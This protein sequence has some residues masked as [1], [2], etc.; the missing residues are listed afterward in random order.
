MISPPQKKQ[1]LED[2]SYNGNLQPNPFF[3]NSGN[4]AEFSMESE[5]QNGIKSEQNGTNGE[6]TAGCNGKASDGTEN[7]CSTSIQDGSTPKKSGLSD[8]RGFRIPKKESTEPKKEPTEQNKEPVEPKKESTQQEEE[9]AELKV[10]ELETTND[11]KHESDIDE[12]SSTQEQKMEEECSSSSSSS[13]HVPRMAAMSFNTAPKPKV[14]RQEPFERPK[15]K[16]HYLKPRRNGENITKTDAK[17]YEPQTFYPTMDEFKDLQKYMNYLETQGA[18]LAGICKIVPPKEWIPRKE[19]YNPND[20]D[21]QIQYPVQQNL[22]RGS[23][24]GA[25]RALAASYPSIP[26]RD[27][28]KLATK[29]KFLPPPHNSYEEL[30]QLYWEQQ[31]DDTREAPIYGADTCD[32]ITDAEQKVWNIRRLDSLL[33]DVLDEQIPGVN[34]PYLYFGMWKATFSWHVEDMDLYSVNYLHYGAPKTWYCV[35]PQYAYKLERV[36][37]K[38]FPEMSDHCKNMMRHKCCMISPKLLEQHGVR[39]HKMQQEERNMIVVF[40]HAYHSGFNHGFNIAESTNFALRRWVE[41]GKRF[42]PCTC[43]DKDDK[44]AFPMEPFVAAVQPD[45]LQEWKEG[46]DWDFHPDDPEFIV[47]AYNDAEEIFKNDEMSEKDFRKFRRDIS[48]LREVP[49]WY[50]KKYLTKDCGK[51]IG[52]E[53]KLKD[54]CGQCEYCSDMPKFGGMDLLGQLCIEAIPEDEKNCLSPIVKKYEDKA[55]MTNEWEFD[56]TDVI[57]SDADEQNKPIVRGPR[58]RAATRDA[59]EKANRTQRGTWKMKMEKMDPEITAGYMEKLREGPE[60]TP[61]I[62]EEDIEASGKKGGGKGVGFAGVLSQAELLERKSM[63][64][65]KKGKQ[66]RFNACRKCTG[67]LKSNCG[68]CMYCLDMP[69][70][71]GH[72]VIKQKCET[73]VCVNPVM[74]MCEFCVWTL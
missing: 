32:S 42:R 14:I 59:K 15:P 41:Y 6:A 12:E 1:K 21:I 33:T 37:A 67:C 3:A 49:K 35:P 16:D 57:D 53:N 40:P 61:K 69:R 72:G 64:K 13:M 9:Q 54:D 65:C 55:W 28:V 70:F 60:A 19:G 20:I 34:M 22:S 43:G 66:H 18:H 48:L 5:Q 8:L 51:C 36:A 38:L 63:S 62:T 71:G 26:V 27:Y 24:R 45:K 68:E 30:E 7:Q 46:S 56:L 29:E 74:K 47:R 39:V 50:T 58:L 11:I 31:Y 52:C 73:R 2:L 10:T 23:E 17:W 4:G 44:V 25:F